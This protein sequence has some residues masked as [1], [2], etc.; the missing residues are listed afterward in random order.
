LSR[1]RAWVTIPVWDRIGNKMNQKTLDAKLAIEN[2]EYKNNAMQLL[3]N[4]GVNVLNVRFF[5]ESI[6]ADVILYFE[7]E[8]ERHYNCEYPI[9]IINK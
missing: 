3:N 6:V 2:Y 8:K 4:S 9:S 5:K 1:Y 7:D